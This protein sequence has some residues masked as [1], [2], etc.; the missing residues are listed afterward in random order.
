MG[1]AASQARFLAITARKA[2]CEFQSMQIAQEKLSIT[3]ELDKATTEYQSAMNATKLVWDPDGSGQNDFPLSYNLMMTPSAVNNYAPYMI[4]SRDGKIVLDS[5]MAAAARAAGIPQEGMMNK[6][7]T[8][9]DPNDPNKTIVTTLYNETYNEFINQMVKNGGMSETSAVAV[10]TVGLIDEV[11]IGAPM[12]DKTQASQMGIN[13]LIAYIDLTTSNSQ[14]GSNAQKQLAGELTYK[15]GTTQKWDTAKNKWEDDIVIPEFDFKTS[16]GDKGDQNSNYLVVNGTKVDGDNYEFTLSDLLTSDITYARTDVKNPS[17]FKK[18]LARVCSIA[19]IGLIDIF[20]GSNVYGAFKDL[21]GADGGTNDF[22]ELDAQE[23]ALINFV[24]D[25]SNSL[26]SFFNIDKDSSETQKEAF[27]YAFQQTVS[28][29]GNV[30]DIG[31]RN[32]SVDAF[33]DA[34]KE[35]NNYNGWVH[36][37]ANKGGNYGTSAISLSNLAESFLTFYAQGLNGY[38]DTYYINQASDKSCY[39]TED[40]Y[41][42]WTVGN[43]DATTA[44]E[45]YVAE[46]Y[47]S[48]FNNLC[49]NGWIENDQIDDNEYLQNTLQ[50]GLYFISSLSTDNYYYQ[51]RYTD[52]GYVYEV[53]DEDAIKEAEIAY[54]QLKNKL[55]A[56]EEKLDLDMKKID[57]EISTL[58]TEYDTVKNLISKNVEKTFTMFN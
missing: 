27:A 21:F 15:L 19:V 28:L 53:K 22:D 52:N 45:M 32:H 1:L 37:T 16:I 31:S 48:M 6:T 44:K 24:V 13:D 39:V 38:D 2:N 9:P 41:Y 49:H 46:F 35:S 57:L 18:F 33:N 12:L 3:R 47:S 8:K 7:I 26:R 4:T 5:A 43:P 14:Y 23:K 34:I 25:M 36:K 10:R 29:L 55:S 40:P 54:A 20:T 56:K 58:T 11:G 17:G 30:E 42:M 50:N 51:N